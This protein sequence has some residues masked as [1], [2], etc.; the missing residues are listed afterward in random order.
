MKEQLKSEIQKQLNQ[1]RASLQRAQGSQGTYKYLNEINEVKRKTWAKEIVDRNAESLKVTHENEL[2]GYLNQAL[3]AYEKAMAAAK[4]RSE[5]LDVN[6]EKLTKA[7]RLIQEMGKEL[8]DEAVSSI[9]SQFIGDQSSLKALKGYYKKN[10]IAHDGLIDTFM[11]DNFG[12]TWDHARSAL[13]TEMGLD[14]YVNSAG[15]AIAKIAR[16]EG[17]EF[18]PAI[19]KNAISSHDQIRGMSTDQV[20][21]N[22]EEIGKFMANS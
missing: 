22:W 7:M 20:N 18:D 9:N 4:K 5:Y 8:T 17:V 16:L 11:Y 19:D 15:Q 10:G 1:V 3:D 13:Y 14:G 21:K 12:R 2:T 6:D